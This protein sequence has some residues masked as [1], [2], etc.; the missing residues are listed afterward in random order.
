MQQVAVA[1]GL[2]A[3]PLGGVDQE[4]RGLAAG[5]AGDHVLEELLVPGSVDDHVV[6][7]RCPE[8]DLGGVDG[9]ALVALGLQR[10]HQKRPLERHAAALAHRFDRLELTLGQGAGVV[11]QAADQ[12][13]FAVVDVA[14]DHDLE[15]GTGRLRHGLRPHM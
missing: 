14:D 8:L 4:Q 1:A 10:I 2:L 11:E 7:R 6:A 15:L 12:G 5:R 9:H 13:R 3:H